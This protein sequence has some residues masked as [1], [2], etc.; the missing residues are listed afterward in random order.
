MLGNVQLIEDDLAVRLRPVLPCRGNV[1]I[2]H[3]HSDRSEMPP[4]CSSVSVPQNPSKLLCLRSSATYSARS[5]FKV[6]HQRQVA[7]SLPKRLLIDT[8]LTDRFGFAALQPA[9][10]CPF[11]DAVYFVPT[12]LQQPR[13]CSNKCREAARGIRPRQFYDAHSVP[14]AFAARR[15]GVEDC[16]ILARIQMRPPPLRLVVMQLARRATFPTPPIDHVVMPQPHVDLF[17]LCR[18]QDDLR[19]LG[20]PRS[21]TSS[22]KTTQAKPGNAT[23]CSTRTMAEASGISEKSVRRIR[24]KNGLR[25]HLLR[26]CKAGNDPQFAE[27][28]ESL[29]V[30][31]SIRRNTRLFSAPTRRARSRRWIA[32]NQGY[33]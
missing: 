26:T 33:H 7:V 2:L 28:L 21:R 29:V 13:Y 9:L 27:K 24:H 16:P 32:P 6:V 31:I 15:L 22:G 10:H 23:R 19:T 18:Q 3:I 30:S 8:D 4:I 5:R 1:G 17:S 25:P 12:E 20:R 14:T 11:Q